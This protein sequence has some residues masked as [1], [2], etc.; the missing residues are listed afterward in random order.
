LYCKNQNCLKEL[1]LQARYCPYCGEKTDLSIPKN[2]Y[3]VFSR[4]ILKPLEPLFGSNF[5]PNNIELQQRQSITKGSIPGLS[6]FGNILVAPDTYK[7]CFQVFE[8][9]N[10]A[11]KELGHSNQITGDITSATT[12]LFDGMFFNVISS[13]VIYRFGINRKSEVINHTKQFFHEHIAEKINN[14]LLLLQKEKRYLLFIARQKLYFI[15]LS[16]EDDEVIYDFQLPSINQDEKWLPIVPTADNSNLFLL[17]SRGKLYRFDLPEKNYQN[18]VTFSLCK[19]FNFI[20]TGVPVIKEDLLLFLSK[21]ING[22][23]FFNSYEISSG[24]AISKEIIMSSFIL[25]NIKDK[26][27][28][29]RWRV[30]LL[31][32]ARPNTAASIDFS[33]A[34]NL[35]DFNAP[36]NPEN[37]L[38]KENEIYSFLDSKISVFNLTTAAHT[39]DITVSQTIGANIS[40][41]S[42][43]FYLNGFISVLTKEKIFIIRDNN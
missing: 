22:N 29:S 36:I 43:M 35:V 15:D 2:S 18:N 34:V 24:K 27:I 23:V 6:G 37:F 19:D 25:P 21:N 10:G 32:I 16:K 7:N 41:L 5:I 12:P 17:S 33:G 8:L 40:P 1:P 3:S 9:D 42:E 28:H 20:E 30:L 4:S 31:D 14:P 11:N 39:Q 26:L 13:N 38:L